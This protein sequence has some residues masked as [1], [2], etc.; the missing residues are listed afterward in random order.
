[1]RDTDNKCLKEV[2]QP[3]F[4]TLDRVVLPRLFPHD[5]V[6]LIDFDRRTLLALASCGGGFAFLDWKKTQFSSFSCVINH[7]GQMI[8]IPMLR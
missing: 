1:M 2:L 4:K 6:T 5:L 8:S 3:E 7:V